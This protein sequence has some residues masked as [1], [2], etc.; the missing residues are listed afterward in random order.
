MSSLVARLAMRLA[1]IVLAAV[2]PCM[3]AA[4]PWS[5]SVDDQSGLPV[6]TKGGASA[7][8]A[9]YAFWGANWAWAGLDTQLVVDAPFRYTVAGKSQRLGLNMTVHQ[10]K[11]P[12]NRLKM[13]FDLE[14]ANTLDKVIGGGIDFK[15]NLA[16]FGAD[17][18][19]PELLPGNAGWAWGH[20]GGDR[21]EMRFDPPLAKVYFERAGKDEIR[22]FFYQGSIPAG[23]LRT[24]ATLSAR[25]ETAIAPTTSE[26]FGAVDQTR[27]PTD[28][29]DW[30]TAPVDLSFLNNPESPA[31]K[32]GFLQAHGDKLVFQDGTAVRFWG[33]NLTAYALFGTSKEGTKQQ[34]RRLSQLGFNL[35]RL[36]H[37]DSPWVNPNIFGDAKAPDTR[38]LSDAQLD[39]L[40]WWIKCLKDEG[41]YVWLDLHVQRM[42][43]P[44]DHIENFDEIA[45]G[46]PSADPKGY[47]YVNASIQ[48]AMKDFARAFLNHRNPYTGK[49]YAEE[50]AV[51]AILLTNENDVTHHYG[52][53]L[54][55]D[56]GVPAHS[57]LYMTLA[58]Q[59]AA[60]WGLPPDRI[61]HAW[62]P[63]PG[64]IFLN[65]LEH[66]FDEDM[67][68]FLRSLG[69][70][71]PISTTSTWGAAP[72]SSLP[73]L[74]SG[75]LIDVHSYGK[76]GELEKNPLY[77]DNFIDWIALGQVAGKPLSVSEW[78][79]ESFPVP[80]RHDA[81]LYVAGSASLQGWD[82]VMIYAYSQA[83][84]DS[85][86]SPS[87]WHAFNDPA[88]I[89]TL[90][91]AALLYRQGH[92]QESP[93][94]Y[95]YTPTP[96]QLFSK[97]VSAANAPG[98][99]TAAE[100]GKL[101]TVMPAVKEL[102][103]LQ[104][105][106][107]PPGAKIIDDPFKPLIPAQAGEIAADTG[108][109]RRNWTSGIYTLDTPRTQAAAGWIGGKTVELK[110]VS[111]AIGTRNVAVAVQSLDGKPIRQSRDLLLSMAAR[112]IPK[113]DRQL[114]FYSEPVEGRISVRAPAGLK[115]YARDA[116]G[117]QRPLPVAYR[118]GRYTIQADPSFKT[119]WLFLH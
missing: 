69:V 109:V 30:K 79:V 70:K 114:P 32:H 9:T 29:L 87:N 47:N 84:L 27:W 57:A 63:G 2:L 8:T 95:A 34:A 101:V 118:D 112:A 90:P 66:R 113:S 58:K 6:I 62:E 54:L 73:A 22:A 92:V 85:A 10:Q 45:K 11:T 23:H 115:L 96:E 37:H 117:Q 17:L 67:I 1:V 43:K 24:V 18:G 44:G 82:A 91:A 80:D 97:L 4:A 21:I 72:M 33:T 77:A 106:T 71:V 51:A 36:H 49:R 20:A 75:D 46:K 74:T 111:F 41:I 68:H 100:L 39:R 99:R 59:F 98:L 86:A 53:A 42:L 19:D 28:I 119:Y 40:D 116:A 13:D 94:V 103:W 110:D 52:N 64:K 107:P 65:D 48:Q 93:L 16:A 14:A 88:L 31:G 50:P 102:P 7:V 5:I 26:K 81:P 38:T 15:F 35:V 89:G 76:V 56:K 108:E 61:W 3:T 60:T 104:K 55:P 83:P 78:N 25:G 105:G 12:D